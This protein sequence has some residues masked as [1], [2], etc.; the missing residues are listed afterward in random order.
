MTAR[1]ISIEAYH[2]HIESGKALV[3]WADIYQFLEE[4]NQGGEVMPFTR[5]ELAYYMELRESSVC[6]RVKEL[7]DAGLIV[8]LPRRKCTVTGHMA[9][10]VTVAE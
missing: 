1:A 10:P 8:E 7:L 3:Q 2:R 4:P 9:H 6:G 5:A